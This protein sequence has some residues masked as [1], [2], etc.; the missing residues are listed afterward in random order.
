MENSLTKELKKILVI[1]VK[2]TLTSQEAALYTG[3]SYLAFLHRVNE[4]THYKPGKMLYFDKKDLDSWMHQNK[5][6]SDNDIMR[7][8]EIFCQNHT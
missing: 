1:G 3:M 2:Q 6:A 4:I 5:I 7:Q 8:A